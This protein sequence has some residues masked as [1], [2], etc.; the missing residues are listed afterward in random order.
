[1]QIILCDVIS[2]HGALFDRDT[3]VLLPTT[4]TQGVLVV[5]LR[6]QH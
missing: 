4:L 1:M 2:D 6:K 3:R 5:A